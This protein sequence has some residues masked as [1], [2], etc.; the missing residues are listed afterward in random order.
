MVR[1]LEINKQHKKTQVFIFQYEIEPISYK[2]LNDNASP[3]LSFIIRKTKV[4]E[5]L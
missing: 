5:F 3:T 2:D 1:N 4:I